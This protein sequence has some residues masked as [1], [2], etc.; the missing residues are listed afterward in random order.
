MNQNTAAQPSTHGN[1]LIERSAASDKNPAVVP[2]LLTP[3]E[4]QAVAGG[5]RIVNDP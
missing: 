5:P 3:T 4:L 2:R 1:D